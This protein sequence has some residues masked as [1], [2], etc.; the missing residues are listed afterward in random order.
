MASTVRILG[1]E[2]SAWNSGFFLRVIKIVEFIQSESLCALLAWMFFS[3]SLS[4]PPLPLPPFPP[5]DTQGHK[6]KVTCFM[7]EQHYR[8]L[9]VPPSL[10]TLCSPACVLLCLSPFSPSWI[11]SHPLCP[12]EPEAQTGS[13]LASMPQTMFWDSDPGLSPSTSR[14]T[15]NILLHPTLI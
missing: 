2:W 9:Q 1:R 11:L 14:C 6:R 5:S 7:P 15:P 4:P 3:P 12:C 8:R 10:L 13:S